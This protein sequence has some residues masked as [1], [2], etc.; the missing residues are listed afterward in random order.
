ME[1]NKILKIYNYVRNTLKI[2]G[3]MKFKFIINMNTFN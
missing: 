2:L 1:S 3:S